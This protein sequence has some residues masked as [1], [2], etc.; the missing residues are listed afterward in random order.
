[1]VGWGVLRDNCVCMSMSI[2]SFYDVFQKSLVISVSKSVIM[3]RYRFHMT[4]TRHGTAQH[5]TLTTQ[6]WSG[7]NTRPSSGSGSQW[8]FLVP[9]TQTFVVDTGCCCCCVPACSVAGRCSRLRSCS[10]AGAGA[11]WERRAAS[12]DRGGAGWGAETTEDTLDTDTT[13]GDIAAGTEGEEPAL[14][15]CRERD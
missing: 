3:T 11:G 6:Q 5:S 9:G 8:M 14:A 12:W 4:R 7:P 1:M 15:E 10:W 13:T 2:M